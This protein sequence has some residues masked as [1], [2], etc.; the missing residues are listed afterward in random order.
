ML[1]I[2]REEDIPQM[3][4]IYAPYVEDTTWSFEYAVP[5]REDFLRRFREITRQFPWIVWEEAG[6]VLGYAYGSAPFG[7]RQAY[8]WC[9]ESSIYLRD[10]V[11]GRGIGAKLCGA[12][13]Q[14]LRDQGYLLLYA[15][16]TS[17]NQV[18]QAFHLAMGFSLRAEFPGCGYKLGRRVGVLWYEKQLNF[19]E[20][21]SNFP[22]SA[23]S[24]GITTQ[25][26][27]DILY[28]LSIS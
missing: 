27:D 16:V 8:A 7:E 10:D 12:L 13:E 14:L 25:K 6:Q 21:P 24:T 17:E 22:A 1:R 19:V 3:L 23:M 4:A 18:S 15:L 9:A 20:S 5:T 2:A 26:T 11:R 28:K